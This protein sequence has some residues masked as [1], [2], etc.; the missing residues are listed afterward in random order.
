MLVRQIIEQRI[1]EALAQAQRTGAL[2]AV[3]IP[4]APVERP[5]NPEH[6]DFASSLPLRLAKP[7]R[8]SPLAI[9]EC[10]AAHVA[11]DGAIGSARAAP[12]GFVNVAL[13]REWLQAQVEAIRAAGAEFGNVDAGGGAVRPGRV[14]ERQPDRARTR[15]PR[16]RR[17]AR[18]RPRRVARG[19]R[20][21][22]QPRVL[23]QRHRHADGAVLRVGVRPVRRSAGP[24]RRTHPRG[25]LSR[26]V[27]GGPGPSAC[28]GLRRPVP[29]DGAG[30]RCAGAWRRGHRPYD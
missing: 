28:R 7:L 11:A 19:R 14:R 26:R 3:D 25:R 4:N 16:A 20:L 29:D 2:P 6:G 24:R 1:A 22:R 15:R 12:P 21:R 23:R 10:V 27:P 17:R 13:S 9:A 30:R 18:Q 5:Q 8:M